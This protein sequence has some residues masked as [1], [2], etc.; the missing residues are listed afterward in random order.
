MTS[1]NLRCK[2]RFQLDSISEF[3][4]RSRLDIKDCITRCIA[5]LDKRFALVA[6]CFPPGRGEDCNQLIQYGIGTD[7]LSMIA[8]THDDIGTLARA[9]V[10]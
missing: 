10:I 7:E 3:L 5:H 4:L 9:K 6:D 8:G 1:G 2:R